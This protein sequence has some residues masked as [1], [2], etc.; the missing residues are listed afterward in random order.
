MLIARIKAGQREE[1]VAVGEYQGEVRCTVEPVQ[2]DKDIVL[3]LGLALDLNL[4]D[5]PVTGGAG[6]RVEAGRRWC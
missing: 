3:G 4:L 2:A 5:A 1:G 6:Y